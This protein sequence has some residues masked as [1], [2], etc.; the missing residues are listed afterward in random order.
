VDSVGLR[1]QIFGLD[2]QRELLRTRTTIP[3]S[4]Q[5]MKAGAVEFFTKPF[6]DHQ[7]LDA[8]QQALDQDRVARAQNAGLLNKQIASRLGIS[9][10][11][12]KVRRAR[13][14]KKL[15][16]KSPIDLAHMAERLAIGGVSVV[17][18]GGTGL[19]R[20]ML[21]EEDTVPLPAPR[22]P[23]KGSS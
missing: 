23:T 21:T 13:M 5:A 14:M 17:A 4:V 16:A 9:E 6:G 20:S 15:K 8:V 11:T 1:G 3:M 10:I 18:V 22:R 19:D 12:V 2:L 7:L